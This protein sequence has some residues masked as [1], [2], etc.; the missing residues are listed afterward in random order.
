ML[1]L[2]P[3]RLSVPTSK[4][5]QK[6]G[7]EF[8]KKIAEVLAPGEVA[9]CQ[10]WCTTHAKPWSTKCFW[11][12]GFCSACTECQEED[13]PVAPYCAGWCAGH[14][15]DWATKC[16]WA[17]NNMC[18]ACLECFP[19]PSS[20]P[21]PLFPSPE[22]PPPPPPPLFPSP[23]MPPPPLAPSPSPP[24]PPPPPSPP[25]P[26]PPSPPPMFSSAGTA[27]YLR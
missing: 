23:D 8:S 4:A 9:A 22:S 7:A 27:K 26:P 19:S 15:K 5:P 1:A 21:P 12:S 14:A 20:P 24:P 2:L 17:G 13:E 6:F 16:N 3:S 10:K 25:P 18:G 11:S